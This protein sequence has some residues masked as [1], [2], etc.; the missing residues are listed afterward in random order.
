M[1]IIAFMGRV[2]D[3]GAQSRSGELA[4]GIVERLGGDNWLVPAE[5]AGGACVS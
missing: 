3:T 4:S 5:P 2:E 1:S